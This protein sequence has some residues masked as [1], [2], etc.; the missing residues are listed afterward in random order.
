MVCRRIRLYGPQAAAGAPR[1]PGHKAPVISQGSSSQSAITPASAA[2][3][4]SEPETEGRADN[5]T[6]IRPG[7]FLTGG[8][9]R[10]VAVMAL[11]ASVGLLAMFLV[12]L[13]DLF[14]ISQ[15][16][17]PSQTAG[18]GFAAT[19]LFCNSAINIGLMITISAL[20]AR[21]IGM[22]RP[23]EARSIATQVAAL[24][25]CFSVPL[26][27][28]FWFCSPVLLRWVGADGTALDTAVLYIRIT[29]PFQPVATFGMICSGFLRA[30]GEARRAM[31]TTLAMAA[32]NA[33]FDPIFMFA[34]GFGFAGAAY[35][36]VVAIFMMAISAFLPIWQLYG[37][38]APL[39]LA[40]LRANLPAIGAIMG[41]AVL[42]NL[43][44]PVGGIIVFSFLAGYSDD[45][46]AAYAVIGRIVPV[47]FCLLF[48][49]SGAVGPIIGQN[50]GAHQLDRVRGT[51]DKAIIFALG[52]MAL[53]WPL[54]MLI[55]R[56]VAAAFGLGEAG[57]SLLVTFTSITAPLFLFNGMLFIANAAFNNLDRPRW[58]TVL[59][60]L[61]N[62]I[63]IVPLVWIG[64][65]IAGAEGIII[66][67][68]LGGLLFGSIAYAM[69]R[70]LVH[71][72]DRAPA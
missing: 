24:G 49:L 19:L 60:W 28:F 51:I 29:A 43:A 42:T 16:G 5:A 21:R 11:T 2:S 20:A 45:V 67:S 14:F 34:L 44:T 32:G 69:T 52:Y 27:A 36:T 41:P 18:M 70:K 61:R 4:D 46:V 63:G 55:D 31:N 13:A 62:T 3:L 68:G 71:D 33:I 66:G 64:D 59:N 57:T 35:A 53:I 8:L 6:A 10:H 25:F 47:A 37:G 50:F 26:A 15:L 38:L 9:M 48:S 54:L 17:D 58:S 22:G 12:D 1:I 65:R 30:H 23:E 56:P 39:R 7:K 72:L 40:E